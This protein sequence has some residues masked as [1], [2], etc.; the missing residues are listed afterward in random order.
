[1]TFFSIF[2]IKDQVLKVEFLWV[3]TIEL[4]QIFF[5]VH[6]CLLNIPYFQTTCPTCTWAHARAFLW[7][8]FPKKTKKI[9]FFPCNL[10]LGRGRV[11]A[12]G[13]YRRRVGQWL[14]PSKFSTNILQVFKVEFLWVPMTESAQF[15]FPGSVCVSSTWVSTCHVPH[16]HVDTC[17]CRFMK[18][19]AQKSKKT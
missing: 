2:S 8:K 12:R 11:A 7:K 16:V 17:T 13:L 18:A 15:F 3:L 4:A 10:S 1:M 19:R 5:H 6:V 9:P 14:S